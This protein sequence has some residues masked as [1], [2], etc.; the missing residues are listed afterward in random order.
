MS[1]TAER[2]RR[3]TVLQQDPS[4]AAGREFWEL[5]MP[6]VEAGFWAL[7]RHIHGQN[8]WTATP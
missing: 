2:H 7:R 6:D 3:I 4:P 8:G 5:A 1:D